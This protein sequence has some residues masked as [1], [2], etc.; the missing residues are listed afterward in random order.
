L[1]NEKGSKKIVLKID[2]GFSLSIFNGFN[3]DT[4][5]NTNMPHGILKILLKIIS[6]QYI[7]A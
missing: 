5:H 1:T 3:C 6:N 4:W 2:G 7:G